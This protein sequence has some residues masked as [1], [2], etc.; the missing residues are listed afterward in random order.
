MAKIKI[1]REDMKVSY[2]NSAIEI[3]KKYLTTEV[4]WCPS[5][6]GDHNKLISSNS[7]LEVTDKDEVFCHFVLEENKLIYRICF[8]G[9]KFNEGKVVD[10]DQK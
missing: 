5:E 9:L 2:D 10:Y 8:L 1:Q 3:G 7:V 6:S 4:L